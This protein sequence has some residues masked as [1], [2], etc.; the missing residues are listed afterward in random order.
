M[1]SILA[2]G[3]EKVEEA[4]APTP[5]GGPAPKC[6]DPQAVLKQLSSEEKIALLSGDDM[7]HTAPVRR[8]GVPRVRVSIST[9]LR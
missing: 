4:F 8:L 6:I 7:W 2:K 9:G 5:P 1:T 3:M